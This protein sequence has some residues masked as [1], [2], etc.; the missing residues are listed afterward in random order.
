MRRVALALFFVA[1]AESAAFAQS[2]S[3]GAELKRAADALVDAKRYE[4]A[5]AL[6]DQAYAKTKDPAIHYNRGRALQ[7]LGRA[8]EALEAFE[9]FAREAPP[10][11]RAKVPDLDG[12][13]A[14]VRASVSSLVLRCPVDGA[15]VIVRDRVVGT[16]PLPGPIAL[17][18]GPANIEITAEGYV[19]FRAKIVLPRGGRLAVDAPLAAI[20]TSSVLT[21]RSSVAGTTVDI[22]GHPVGDAPAES[23][24][25]PGSH[26]VRVHHDGYDDVERYFVTA[27]GE[28]RTVSIDPMAPPPIT[29]KWWF[30][31][32]VGVVVVGGIALTAALLTEKPGGTGDFSPGRTTAPL[33]RF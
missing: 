8:P 27:E 2:A 15:R 23:T 9:R 19:P 17:N 1:L 28:H 14:E 30:W 3:T 5:V 11:V 16:A 13:I 29:S 32:G 7:F 24:V 21:V 4:D 26:R 6:Y 18:A 25:E 31:T 33:V 20:G 12:L 10:A 22:D